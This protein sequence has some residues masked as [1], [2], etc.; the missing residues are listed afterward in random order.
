[1][2]IDLLLCICRLL[3]LL[4]HFFFHFFV[5]FFFIF[6][7]FFASASFASQPNARE[8]HASGGDP[9]ARMLLCQSDDY[10]YGFDFGGNSSRGSNSSGASGTN[11]SSGSGGGGD[12]NSSGGVGRVFGP[13]SLATFA[14]SQVGSSS[15]LSSTSSFSSSSMTG[16]GGGLVDGL[17]PPGPEA[18]SLAGNPAAATAAVAGG[19]GG[20]GGACGSG[21]WGVSG[22]SSPTLFA[23]AIAGGAA[24]KVSWV[25]RE[26]GRGFGECRSGGVFSSVLREGFG[27]ANGPE[28]CLFRPFAFH[29]PS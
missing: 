26:G 27:D 17:S 28:K 13:S 22:R 18:P 11:S 16:T 8:T 9:V 20:R 14:R 24:V 7:H 12:Q 1:M 15:L 6:F 29:R 3:L 21:E 23:A 4:L 2:L 5:S 25:K 19:R 10:D